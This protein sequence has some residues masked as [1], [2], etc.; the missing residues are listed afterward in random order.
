MGGGKLYSKTREIGKTL[1]IQMNDIPE[2]SRD[3]AI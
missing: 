3:L 2:L 1:R